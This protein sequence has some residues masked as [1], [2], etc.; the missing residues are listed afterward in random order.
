MK[1]NSYSN[2]AQV[3][4]EAIEVTDHPNFK[5]IHPRYA[6]FRN[7]IYDLPGSAHSFNLMRDMI[8]LHLFTGHTAAVLDANPTNA[9]L[10]M[11]LVAIAAERY[12][13]P[14]WYVPTHFVEVAKN[15][16]PPT[17]WQ[18]NEVP[19]PAF[20]FLLPKGTLIADEG[21]D[22]S[23]IGVNV[24][25]TSTNEKALIITAHD[26]QGIFWRNVQRISEDNIVTPE[27][28]FNVNNDSGET[29]SPWVNDVLMPFVMTLLG[30]MSA[31]PELVGTSTRERTIKKS[32][33]E[34]WTPRTLGAKYRTQTSRSSTGDEPS[35]H[36]RTHWRKGHLRSQ[37]YGPKN[38]L[39]RQV[40]IDPVLVNPA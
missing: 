39:I 12:D 40:F 9:A 31:R 10:L 34:V 23:F 26:P 14:W 32:G 29:D 24:G 3:I 8:G 37:H 7:R 15:V 22:I 30:I 19:F 28:K 21:E 2:M 38:T 27:Y 36:V 16:T 13:F 4:K 17:Y 20:Y 35:Y 1:A 11:G 5:H 6:A 33:K 18:V 25:R